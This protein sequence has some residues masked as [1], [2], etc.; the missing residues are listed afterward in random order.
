MSTY[1]P[2]VIASLCLMLAVGAVAAVMILLRPEPADAASTRQRQFVFGSVWVNEQQFVNLTYANTGTRPTP[3]A[4]VVFR[5]APG[6]QLF[7]ARLPSVLPGQSISA[8]RDVGNNEVLAVLTFDPPA[9]GQGIPSPFPGTLQVLN[10]YNVS[11]P[12]V[13]VAL[14]PVP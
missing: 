12:Q 3:E 11:R 13:Q 5:N 14:Y 4:S 2:R 9:A 8:G 6:G 1:R 10:V 7:S